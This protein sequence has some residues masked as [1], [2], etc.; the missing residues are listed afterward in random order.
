MSSAPWDSELLILLAVTMAHAALPCIVYMRGWSASPLL[1]MLRLDLLILCGYA[2]WRV[3]ILR[4]L[5]HTLADIDMLYYAMAEAGLLALSFLPLPV[6]LVWSLYGLWTL[7]L[8][9]I[10]IFFLTFKMRLF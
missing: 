4:D 6:W 5:G 3:Y 7:L 1:W 8:A 10:S 2:L 9:A